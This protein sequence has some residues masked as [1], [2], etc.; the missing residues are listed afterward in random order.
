M[1]H[2]SSKT[3]TLLHSL[4]AN[5]TR[6]K[7]GAY[8]SSHTHFSHWDGL[9]WPCPSTTL[10][11]KTTNTHT[12]MRARSHMHQPTSSVADVCR[13]QLDYWFCS[14]VSMLTLTAAVVLIALLAPHNENS[15][16]HRQPCTEEHSR[17]MVGGDAPF[18]RC[19]RKGT[20]FFTP[21]R[22]TCS[23]GVCFV[24]RTFR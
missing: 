10:T 12:H 20:H 7:A 9:V 1:N 19:E 5:G 24:L 18:S 8:T 3:S 21:E 13:G 11:L 2:S 16:F 14:C 6:I 15:S 17:G 4:P 23:A 22:T